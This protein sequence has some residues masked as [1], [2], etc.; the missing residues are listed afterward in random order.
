MRVARRAGRKTHQPPPLPFPTPFHPSFRSGVVQLFNAISKSQRESHTAEVAG[1]KRGDAAAAGRAAFLAA[2]RGERSDAAPT[3]LPPGARAAAADAAPAAPGGG[4]DSDDPAA[5]PSTGA[6][7]WDVLRD[8]YDH[9]Q[10]GK[11][12]LKA[13]DVRD[14]GAGDGPVGDALAG[15][16]SNDGDGEGGGGW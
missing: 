12:R 2:L 5:A 15:S 3:G 9:V 4:D 7:G 1:R 10:G 8:D 13:W 6:P 16:S 14:S 11:G